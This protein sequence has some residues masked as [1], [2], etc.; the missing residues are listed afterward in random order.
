VSIAGGNPEPIYNRSGD[1]IIG[2]KDSNVAKDGFNIM[3]LVY[4]DYLK[5]NASLC[6]TTGFAAAATNSTIVHFVNAN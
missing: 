4:Y 5:T 1:N 3:F 2:W 6:G